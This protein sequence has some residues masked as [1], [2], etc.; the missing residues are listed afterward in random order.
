MLVRSIAV[1]VTAIAPWI[2]R[3]AVAVEVADADGL[4]ECAHALIRS[5]TV[6]DTDSNLM[7]CRIQ[8][9]AALHLDVVP[10]Y[11]YSVEEDCFFW[12]H[13]A[14]RDRTIEGSRHLDFNKLAAYRLSEP[15]RPPLRFNGTAL[16]IGA[17]RAG[18]DAA[19]LHQQNGLR[20]HLFEPSPTFFQSL[21][22]T[23]TGHPD[24]KLYNFGL[25]AETRWATLWQGETGSR[26][27]DTS[28]HGMF[29]PEV[30]A[31]E[32][33]VLI[34]STA[35]AIPEILGRH[36]NQSV[37]LLHVNC[38]GCEYDV[39]AG[40][41]AARL[42]SRVNQVQLATHLLEH[43]EPG[44]TFHENVEFSMQVSVKRYCEMHRHLSETHERVFGLPWVWERWA[45]RETP[46]FT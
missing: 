5:R 33:R 39:I 25:G 42:L 8:L 9:L 1:A 45:R 10:G 30:Q 40:L 4:E 19:F 38:E 37:E 20:M 2:G 3:R 31:Q 12:A 36:G 23:F 46:V 17:H 27:S 16:Y 18:E 13:F 11:Q 15:F 44:A 6:G 35:E 14:I 22:E 34:R 29:V 32:E 21:R 28:R 43:L 41:R 26:T 7:A 24:F